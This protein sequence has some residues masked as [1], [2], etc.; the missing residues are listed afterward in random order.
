MAEHEGRSRSAQLAR[1][2]AVQHL[3]LIGLQILC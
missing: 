2:I 1:S 3:S